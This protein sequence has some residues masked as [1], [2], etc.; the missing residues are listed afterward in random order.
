MAQPFIVPNVQQLYI[1][2]GLPNGPQHGDICTIRMTSGQWGIGDRYA[3]VMLDLN[4]AVPTYQVQ[5]GPVDLMHD[6]VLAGPQNV[7]MAAFPNLPLLPGVHRHGPLWN[8]N[9]QPGDGMSDGFFPITE[10]ELGALQA[11]NLPAEIRLLRDVLLRRN[12]GAAAAA[13]AGPVIPGMAPHAIPIAQIRAV[14]GATPTEAKKV[15]LWIGR[16]AQAIEGIFPIANGVIRMRIINALT[17]G[18]VNLI[19][20]PG[21]ADTWS[22]AVSNLYQR[23]YGTAAI[24]QLPQILKDI[25]NTD[26]A[27]VAFEL[28]MMFSNDYNLVWGIIRSALP[29]QAVVTNAQQQLALL[30]NDQA[31]AQAFPGI[32]RGIY[33]LLGL[34][35]WGKSTRSNPP[36]Q[37]STPVRGTP[38]SRGRG[39]SRGRGAFAG[40]GRGYTRPVPPPPQ[41]SPQARVAERPV[42]REERRYNFRSNTYTPNWFGRGR[43]RNPYRPDTRAEEASAPAVATPQSPRNETN[44][45]DIRGRG[46]GGSRAVNLVKTETDQ[47]AQKV[48]DGENKN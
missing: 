37:T 29:G 34:D 47:K 42:E 19:L 17:A 41:S 45:G 39:T 10:Q 40:R 21:E 48:A 24:H 35:I 32:L 7:I 2:T 11:A 16:N 3:R 5:Q 9:Y 38:S 36:P 44:R 33:Q 28:G 8:G 43:G 6:V 31:R 30:P 46:R 4:V 13:A 14:V 15:P 25:A 23:A 26:G 1:Q 27:I 18:F 22:Q 20:A 12:I